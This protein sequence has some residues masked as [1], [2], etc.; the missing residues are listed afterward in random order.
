VEELLRYDSPVQVVSRIAHCDLMLD[1]ARVRKG[2]RVLVVLGAA[3][4]DPHRYPDPDR[5]D[6]ARSGRSH[7]AFGQG[8]HFCVGAGLAR[9][10]AQETFV[11]LSQ[12]LSLLSPGAD[13]S[14][15]RSNSWSHQRDDSSALRR[16]GA[17]RVVSG[18]SRPSGRSLP[19]S[20]AAVAL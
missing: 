16:L 18:S 17:L 2:E 7:L 11:R 20:A 4:R 9:L 8:P 19:S 12:S 6:I 14:S 13:T 5:L 3:N 10:E 1:G 15:T